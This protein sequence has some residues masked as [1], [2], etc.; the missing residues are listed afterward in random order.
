MQ[1]IRTTKLKIDI[2][3]HGKKYGNLLK[4][5]KNEYIE[6]IYITNTI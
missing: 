4:I 6:E 2:N 1:L 3:K 5:Y